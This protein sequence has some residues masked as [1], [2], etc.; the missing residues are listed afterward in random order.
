MR[1]IAPITEAL[2]LL[3]APLGKLGPA[4]ESAPGA[5]AAGVRPGIAAPC[6]GVLSTIGRETA[7]IA[8]AAQM[9]AGHKRGL[10]ASPMER[11]RFVKAYA[12]CSAP[13]AGLIVTR[14]A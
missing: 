11:A 13:P 10:R 9:L 7:S 2:R 6:A 4:P 3:P 8:V 14:S 5:V 1:L 12:R